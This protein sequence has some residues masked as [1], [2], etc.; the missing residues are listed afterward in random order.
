MPN[1]RRALSAAV[2]E[3]Y[4]AYV[5]LAALDGVLANSDVNAN[6]A[7]VRSFGQLPADLA[8]VRPSCLSRR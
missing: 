1:R 5:E 3:F 6:C 7:D 8:A 2:D 4:A